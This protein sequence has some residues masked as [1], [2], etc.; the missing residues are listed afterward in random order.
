MVHVTELVAEES[1]RRGLRLHEH[2]LPLMLW[3][4]FDWKTGRNL[5]PS[6]AE[7]YMYDAEH[8]TRHIDTSEEFTRIEIL[9]NRWG[10]LT[11]SEREEVLQAQVARD[12]M[13]RKWDNNQ[14]WDPLKHDE[15]DDQLVQ[16]SYAITQPITSLTGPPERPDT[17]DGIGI[18][19]LGNVA[20]DSVHNPGHMTAKLL[21]LERKF[22][23]GEFGDSDSDEDSV[24]GDLDDGSDS[25]NE[26]DSD[27][28]TKPDGSGGCCGSGTNDDDK[29]TW[30][31]TDAKDEVQLPYSFSQTFAE[32][33]RKLRR[34]A[35]SSQDPEGGGGPVLPADVLSTRPIYGPRSPVEPSPSPHPNMLPGDPI[36][37]QAYIEQ[38]LQDLEEQLSDGDEETEIGE[39]DEWEDFVW[40]EA[41]RDLWNFLRIEDPG[42][43]AP[44]PGVPAGPAPDPGP[45]GTE[46]GNP[47][48]SFEYTTL[49]EIIEEAWAALRE[50]EEDALEAGYQN[51]PADF[52]PVVRNNPQT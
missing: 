18:E 8:K 31:P 11:R 13:L 5:C 50:A 47:V 27:D 4:S 51:I 25:D 35:S 49:E 26:H 44:R 20:D 48:E 12:D 21:E 33:E 36:I 30:K 39:E 24:F 29:G 23:A 41:R 2:M 38:D 17:F 46:S 37:D 14:L 10:S 42:P 43:T 28:E 45:V 7:I 22:H 9:K 3:G 16:L 34:A 1:C 32:Y 19:P 52:R 40:G 6:E 15:E